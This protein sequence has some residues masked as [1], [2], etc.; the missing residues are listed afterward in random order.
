[1][2]SIDAAVIAESSTDVSATKSR[3]WSDERG[4]VDMANA[5]KVVAEQPDIQESLQNKG[6]DLSSS[7]AR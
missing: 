2:V 7:P 5:V 4:R 6:I 3:T 1:V